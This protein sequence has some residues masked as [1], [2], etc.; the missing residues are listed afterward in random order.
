MVF[1][2]VVPSLPPCF[3]RLLE[4]DR[5]VPLASPCMGHAWLRGARAMQLR[6]YCL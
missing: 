6:L 5:A 1:L 4:L 2:T 3:C